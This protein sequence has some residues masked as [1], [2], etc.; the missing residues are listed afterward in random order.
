M[1]N[2][3]REIGG[4]PIGIVDEVGQG[5][6]IGRVAHLQKQGFKVI[7][8]GFSSTSAISVKELV[9][10]TCFLKQQWAT[11]RKFE[12]KVLG[13]YERLAP[14]SVKASTLKS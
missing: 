7:G 6:L 2:S 3:I 12:L 13:E 5:L 8:A 4:K 14:R 11:D 10:I 9:N 1:Q